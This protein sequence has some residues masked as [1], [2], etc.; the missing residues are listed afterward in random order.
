MVGLR[1]PVAPRWLLAT[2]AVSA[3]LAPGLA[4][5]QLVANPAATQTSAGGQA[6]VIVQGSRTT[7]I[8][9]NAPRTILGW[10]SF[11]LGSDQSVFF[12]FQ[13]RGGIVLNKI[14]GVATINGQVEALVGAERGAGNVWFQAPGGVIFGPNAQINV[15]GLLA[16]PAAVTEA[17]FLDPTSRSFSFA[18]GAAGTVRVRSG[19]QLKASGGALALIAGAVST[20]TGVAITASGG[21]TILY[22]AAGDFTVRFGPQ[23]GDLDLLDF[24]VPT[25]GGSLSATPLD[26][27]GQ[28]VAS[29]VILAVVNRASV[30]SA[31][32]NAPGLIAA[33]SA[34]ADRGD[35]VL[36][37]G[38]DV[39]G[40]QPVGARTNTTTETTANF[41]AL[42]AQRDLLGGFSQPTAV[43]AT[44]LNAGRDIGLT[45]ASLQAG[46]VNAGRL[47]VLDASRGITLSGG[48]FAGATASLRTGGAL[49]VGGGTGAIAASGRLQ[50]DV[51]T[52]QAGRLTSGRSLVVNASG[53]GASGG[54]AVN[55]AGALA[56]D[57]ITI[58][59]TNAAG[60]ITLGS[61]TLTGA[62]TDEAPAGRNLSLIARG[63]QADVTFGAVGGSRLLGATIVTVAAGRDATLNIAAGSSVPRATV[64]AGRD[65]VL[66]LAGESTVAAAAVAAG[67]D[68][69]LNA[70]GGSAVTGATF[71]AGRD[72]ILKVADRSP[73]TGAT[74]TA[75]HDVILNAAG[76]SAV[77][78]ATLSAGNDIILTV[79]DRS[80]LTGASIT[81]SHDV[82]LNAAGGSAVAGATVKAG[83]DAILN[84]SDGSPL[85]G[86]SVAAGRDAILN[87]DGLVTLKASSA[88]RTFFISAND[89]DLTGAL[90]A[91][92]LRVESRSGGLNIGGGGAS[93]PS[94][95]SSAGAP[96]VRAPGVPM[97]VTDAEFQFIQVTDQASFYASPPGGAVRGD[98]TVEDLNLNPAPIPRLLLAAGGD[99]D[100]LVTGVLAP[101][102][103]GGVLSIGE[104]GGDGAFRPGRILVTGAIGASTGTL[105]TGYTGIRAFDE[106]NLFATRD[107]I[108]GA[109]RF[110]ALIAATPPDKIDPARNMPAG[111]A[112]TAEERNRVFVTAGVLNIDAARRIVQQNSGTIARPNGLFLTSS[113]SGALLHLGAADVIDISG[114]HRDRNGVLQPSLVGVTEVTGQG[115]GNVR[116]NGCS[117]ECS[118]TTAATPQ[119]LFQVTE[120]SVTPPLEAAVLGVASPPLVLIVSPSSAEAED[121]LLDPVALATGSAEIWRKRRAK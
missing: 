33:Q 2:C 108:M 46:P 74:A 22:A 93:A 115:G 88:G 6:P 110:V 66:N 27:Q 15:G 58:T 3:L 60:S 51:G 28:T 41:G 69:I 73:L 43:T 29:G 121:I 13:D 77:A 18:G 26:L 55:V 112:A 31:V 5:A 54:A 87:V 21:A 106:V 72:A 35:I 113:A 62:R 53:P 98:L 11:N 30:A 101:T 19:A 20:E 71:S 12:R 38:V 65:A 37:A 90:T 67:R 61:A 4:H 81:A 45:A 89:L 86:A 79:T 99:N 82:I 84:A 44:Q 52:V 85:T 83:R 17:G 14:S 23:A 42:V 49:N 97:R 107:V 47:L 104:S 32:I 95:A 105:D 7:D 9:L 25:G 102:V 39:V 111:A 114:I 80:P 40:R 96:S 57:D 120:D 56:E 24:T 78:G 36:A 48:A 94:D 34:S 103:N 92:N 68:A 109:A 75:G 1:P 117:D 64:S 8:T 76:G 50:L 16:T 10:S 116:F 100:V 91:A 63:A 118:V 119:K 70:T 59:S